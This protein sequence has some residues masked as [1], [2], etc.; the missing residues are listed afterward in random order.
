MDGGGREGA[1]ESKR[2]SEGE[3]ERERERGGGAER[4]IFRNITNQVIVVHHERVCGDCG[5]K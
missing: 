4:R 5:A 3:G 2:E 1:R